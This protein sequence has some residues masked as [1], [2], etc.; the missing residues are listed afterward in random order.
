MANPATLVPG[1]GGGPQPGAGRP[2]EEFRRMCREAVSRLDR[3]KIAEKVIENPD[4]PAWLGAFRFLAE[5]GYGKAKESVEHSGKAL[6][7]VY[8][9]KDGEEDFTEGV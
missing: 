3:F 4:H 9:V 6:F 7:K 8:I 5:M 1:A 2:P